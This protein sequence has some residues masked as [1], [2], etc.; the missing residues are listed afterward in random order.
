M[1]CE[2][3]DEQPVIKK[4][5]KREAPNGRVQIYF[6]SQTGTAEGYAKTIA[7]EANRRGFD[8]EVIDLEDFDDDH[9]TAPLQLFAM[10]TYGEGEPTDNAHQFVDW[11]KASKDSGILEGNVSRS[12]A[13]KQ[14]VQAL[15]LHGQVDTTVIWRRPAQSGHGGGSRG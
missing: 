3:K 6:G 4:K 10:A 9:M 7:D 15:Q 11:L 2:D 14:A 13:S 12:S 8:A 1:Y 5:Q